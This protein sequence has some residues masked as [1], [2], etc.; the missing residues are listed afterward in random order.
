MYFELDQL[1]Q[2]VEGIEFLDAPFSRLEIDN[3]VND[4]PLGKSPGS[5]GFSSDFIKKC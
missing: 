3:I 1:I 2:E 5:D 4:L